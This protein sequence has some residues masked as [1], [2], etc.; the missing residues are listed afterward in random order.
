MSIGT[1]ARPGNIEADPQPLE[2]LMSVRPIP[3][4]LHTITPHIVCADANSAIDFYKKAFDAVEC[5]RFPGPDGKLM[6]GAIRIGDSMLMLGEEMP[7]WGALGPN[8][9]KGTPVVLALYVPDVDA[10]VAKAVAAGCTVTVPVADMFWGDRYGQI[11]DPYGHRWSL[12]THTRDV[13]PAE[14]EEAMKQMRSPG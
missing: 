7:A 9:L 6:H 5:A 3:E 11:S 12:A 10:S 1:I 2:Q 14:M 8:A 4:G 13:S